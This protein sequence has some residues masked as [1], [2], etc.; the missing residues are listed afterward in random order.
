MRNNFIVGKAVIQAILDCEIHPLH[1]SSG[2]S[3]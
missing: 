3:R 2:Q 1:E